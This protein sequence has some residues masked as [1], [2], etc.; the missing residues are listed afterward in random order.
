MAQAPAE[1][2]VI[3]K[4]YD[5]VVWG[6]RH[7]AR[8]PR[9][10]RFTVGDR[11]QRQLELILD[12]LLRAKFSRDRAGLLREANLELEVLRFQFRLAKDLHCLSLDSFGHAARTVNEVGQMVGGWLK[13]ADRTQ[14]RPPGGE[15]P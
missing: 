11:L 6:S 13:S 8:F 9:V 5:L 10:H 3:Q 15:S 1:L 14:P 7:V 4:T 2:A 12:R